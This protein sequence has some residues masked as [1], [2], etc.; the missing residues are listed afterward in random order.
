MQLCRSLNSLTLPLFGIRMKTDLFQSCGHCWVFQ[1]YWHIDC[2]I[3]TASSFRI[4]SSSAGIHEFEQAPGKPGMLQSMGLQSQTWL[5]DWR[6]TA[7]I[8]SPPLALFIVMFPK[9]LW[10][11]TPGYLALV[12]VITLSWLFGSSK[13]FLYSSSVYS[14]HPFLIFSASVRSYH[15]CPLLCPSLHEMFPWYL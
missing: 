6:T 11:H 14:W 2:S 9:A 5:S 7:G 10:L 13:S 12:W 4:C 8:P 1:I 15:F 3:L